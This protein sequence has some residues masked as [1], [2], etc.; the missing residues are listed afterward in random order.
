MRG[1]QMST[2][3]HENVNQF[4]GVC[5]LAPNVSILM[6][7]AYKGCL[8]DVLQNESIKINA[9][10]LHSFVLDIAA[11]CSDFFISCTCQL[12]IDGDGDDDYDDVDGDKSVFL[13]SFSFID[14]LFHDEDL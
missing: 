12:L 9:D 10:F 14:E 7:Y 4:V 13:I 11:V 6:Q 5:I 3:K 2:I 8:R 1:V